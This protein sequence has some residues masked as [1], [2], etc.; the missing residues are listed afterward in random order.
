MKRLLTLIMVLTL[1]VGIMAQDYLIKT[2]T[3]NEEVWDI[4]GDGYVHVDGE[5]IDFYYSGHHLTAH[6]LASSIVETTDKYGNDVAMWTCSIIDNNDLVGKD[7][8]FTIIAGDKLVF[9]LMSK[10][11]GDP[12][13]LAFTLMAK[14]KPTKGYNL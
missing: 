4:N 11:K 7:M 10:V 13:Y 1:G 6:T 5:R 9:M 8:I 3:T 12:F 2:I 14:K